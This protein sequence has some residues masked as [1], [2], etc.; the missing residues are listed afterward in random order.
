MS[1]VCDC[2]IP[3]ASYTRF[4][5]NNFGSWPGKHGGGAH[6]ICIVYYGCTE[7]M[8]PLFSSAMQ[9]IDTIF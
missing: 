6:P 7:G 9:L 1:A 5:F 3:Q 2:G 8:P 4:F